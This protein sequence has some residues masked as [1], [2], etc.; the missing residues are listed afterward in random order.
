MQTRIL[1]LLWRQSAAGRLEGRNGNRRRPDFG[2]AARQLERR[3]LRGN[4]KPMADQAAESVSGWAF[5]YFERR[6]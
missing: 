4:S 1:A 6:P 5:S 2:A 3:R